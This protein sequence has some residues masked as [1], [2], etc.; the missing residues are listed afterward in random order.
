MLL[1]PEP[2]PDQRDRTAEAVELCPSGALTYSG[3]E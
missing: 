1:D 3:S 2:S